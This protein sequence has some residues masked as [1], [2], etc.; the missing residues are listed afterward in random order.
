VAVGVGAGKYA[1]GMTD[2]DDAYAEIDAG[3][4]VTIVYPDS[5][6]KGSG[7]LF[8]PNTVAMIKNCPHP[9]NARKLV[10][11]LL[12]AG[13]EKE[14]ALSESRQVPLNPQV[15]LDLPKHLETPQT[16]KALPVDFARA[17]EKWQAS[18]AFLVKEFALR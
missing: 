18:Q 8:I 11:F 7:V 5:D 14:L 2:T 4:P 12:G 13:V 16:V 10:D 6:P 1:I 15:K 17:A 3:R 9:E